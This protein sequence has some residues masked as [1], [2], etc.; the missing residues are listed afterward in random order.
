MNMIIRAYLTGHGT[1]I[2]MCFLW[3][4]WEVF[5]PYAAI[6]FSSCKYWHWVMRLLGF[7]SDRF[8]CF[9]LICRL[10]MLV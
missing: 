3:G 10:A 2:T 4:G 6:L 9:R 8:F 1:S 7:G 5:S